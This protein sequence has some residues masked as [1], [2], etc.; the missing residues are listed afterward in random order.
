MSIAPVVVRRLVMNLTTNITIGETGTDNARA[1]RAGWALSG[2]ALLFLSFDSLIKLVRAA[3]A[4]EGT[5]QLGYPTSVVFGLGLVQLLCV[6]AYAIPRTAVVGAVLLTGYLGG[7]I[8][9][10]V[11][12]GN[13]LFT[14]VLFPIYVAVFVWGGLYLRDRRVR[15]LLKR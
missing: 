6:V 9:T 5:A 11:R 1:T 4:V 3:P 8:A 12:M 2:I 10:H 13:P 7:A 15:A 14:H